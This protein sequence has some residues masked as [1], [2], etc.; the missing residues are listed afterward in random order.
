M[1]MRGLIFL[2]LGAFQGH[3]KEPSKSVLLSNNCNFQL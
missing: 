2:A 3:F 1:Q